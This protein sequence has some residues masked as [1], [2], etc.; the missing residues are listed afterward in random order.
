MDKLY[1]A[2]N[3]IGVYYSTDVFDNVV[4]DTR[5]TTPPKVLKNRFSLEMMA[6]AFPQHHF[7]FHVFD[8]QLQQNIEGGL[9]DFYVRPYHEKSNPKKYE[10]YS[11]PFAVLTLKELEAGF[12]VCLVPLL[13]TC[14]A[15]CIEWFPTLKDLMTFF[16]IYK[17]YFNVKNLE[18]E[19]HVK[20]M[21]KRMIA[22]QIMLQKT[23]G[24]A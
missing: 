1:T 3:K 9:T 10:K 17:T 24:D 13:L 22:A 15:F 12:V 4:D 2:G 21:K 6:L 7:L 16:F 20:V 23:N 18:Q 19:K 5:K 8:H 11:Q 14:V